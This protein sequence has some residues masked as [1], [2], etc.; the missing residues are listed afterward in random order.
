M[1]SIVI[2]GADGY[3]GRNLT[4]TFAKKYHVKTL[5][6]ENKNSLKGIRN[7]ETFSGT[8]LKRDDLDRVIDYG[9]I[10][11]NLAGTTTLSIEED[12]HFVLNVLAQ[13]VV[14]QVCAEKG[15]RVICFSTSYIYSSGRR[16]SKESD[17]VQ[18]EDA[19]SFSKKLGEEIYEFYSRSRNLPVVV[20]RL[21]SVYGPGHRKG[22]VFT[23]AESLMKSGII[24]IPQQRT[25]RDLIYID[26]V[27]L[28]VEKAI[29]YY[30]K[31]YHLFNIT[32]GEAQALEKLAGIICALYGG[33]KIKR[34]GRKSSPAII[35]ASIAHAERELK[36]RPR[37][38]LSIGL[39]KTLASY[40]M[41]L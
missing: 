11:I 13:Q 29:A 22:V 23:M 18:P 33:G 25:V 8:I 20:F 35:H 32:S 31:G 39:R 19:Y 28:A 17:A 16:L 38:E 7:V 40:K 21:G 4:H 2:L 34:T 41:D 3:I 9:D 37:T 27:A 24:E 10:V 14:A 26:D 6:H 1:K 36:F 12:R 30:K 5:A 15:A